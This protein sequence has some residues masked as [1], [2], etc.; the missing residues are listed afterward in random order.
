MCGI[1]AIIDKTSSAGTMPIRRM[2]SVTAHRGPDHSGE[3]HY[4][5]NGDRLFLGANRLRIRDV[6]ARADQPMQD[7][8]GKYAL[9]FNGEIYNFYDLKN[10]LI[11]KGFTFISSSDT[12]VLLNWLIYKGRKGIR[13]LDG[14]FSFV[15]AD[16]ASGTVVA[17]RDRWGM[18]P[19]YYANNGS[20]VILS[21]ELRGVLSSGLVER[22]LNRGRVA[23]YLQYKY[24]RR[25]HTFYDGVME[26]EP[27]KILIYE[28]GEIS[29]ET[30]CSTEYNAPDNSYLQ[31]D[32][33]L[34]SKAEDLLRSGLVTHL[35]SDV[36]AGLLLSGGVDSTLLLA[37][38][39]EEGYTMPTFS[40]VNRKRDANYG[41]GDY[42][43]ARMAALQYRS[44]HTELEVDDSILKDFDLF[45]RRLD[46]PVADSG[47]WMTYLICREAAGAIKVLLSG[48]GADELFGGYNRHKAF[49][50]YLKNR[51]SIKIMLPFLRYA[52]S[53]VPDGRNIPWRKQ[54]RLFKRWAY[55]LDTTP[56]ETWNRMIS[57]HE[58][59]EMTNADNWPK[60]KETEA[61]MQYALE[62]DRK[63]YLISDVLTISDR[64]S[65]LNGVEMR[66]PYLDGSLSDFVRRI[67]PGKLLIH[68]GKNILKQILIAYGGKKFSARNKEGFGLPLGNWLRNEKHDYLWELFSEDDHLIFD[69]VKRDK[70]SGLIKKHRQGN[71]DLSQELWSVLVLGY[72][73]AKEFE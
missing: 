69:F 67:P 46:Q 31:D 35:Q 61:I 14:M 15:F 2:L 68:G 13:L 47:A 70:I 58:F 10:E 28:N 23:H 24:A 72:W 8:A 33:S 26:L 27:G 16:L 54:F 29:T 52:G 71:V 73:L 11:G 12:E 43:Y 53:M 34:L 62:D 4:R 3:N 20:Q 7:P 38:A 49:Y 64:M 51:K 59:A 6:T 9:I 36:P 17:A 30:Y 5:L 41:T 48:A 18:K 19:L 22:K 56:R 45:I 55:S 37:L 57:M 39:R 1:N 25:P 32:S 40:I 44:D 50:W 21:S 66:M 65:M 63:N 60:D 42:K